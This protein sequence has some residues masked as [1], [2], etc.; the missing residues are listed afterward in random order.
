[1][2]AKLFVDTWGWLTLN[3]QRE[4]QH[5][6]VVELYK[7]FRSQAGEIYTT[8]YVLDETFTLFFKRL[9]SKQ[10]QRSMTILI[11]VFKEENFNLIR[12]TPERFAQTQA[13]RIK[14]IDKPQISFTD[15]T[16]MVV[17]KEFGIEAVLTGDSH[18]TQV[19]MGFQKTPET[20]G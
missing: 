14:Y 20:F 11:N 15:L 17:M 13:L 8:D 1:M 16:S 2:R 7:S 10:A 6:K 4:S 9:I 12:I 18:F 3:D 5:Q 19:G